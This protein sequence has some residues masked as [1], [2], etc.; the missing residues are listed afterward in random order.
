MVERLF[1][2]GN[3]IRQL[4]TDNETLA[5]TGRHLQARIGESTVQAS[6]LSVEEGETVTAVSGTLTL[7]DSP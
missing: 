3:R 5:G 2:D 7:P 4:P 6:R 1:R